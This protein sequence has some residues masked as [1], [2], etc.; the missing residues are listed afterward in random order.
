MN[1]MA[2]TILIW[3]KEA[4]MKQQVSKA[5]WEE[6]VTQMPVERP[7]KSS[8]KGILNWARPKPSC[9]TSS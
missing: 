4:Q 5:R 9:E 8:L 7:K 6:S 2:I 3:E 1:P